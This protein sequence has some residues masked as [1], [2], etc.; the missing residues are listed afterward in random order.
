MKQYILSSLMLIMAPAMMMAQL[1]TPGN[2]TTYSL[3]TLARLEG[4]G[5][6]ANGETGRLSCLVG[7]V[8]VVRLY[9]HH[10]VV[11]PD[12]CCHD[13]NKRHSQKRQ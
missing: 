5:V 6:T 11:T 2:G 7:P 9:G 8:L 3:Q 10:N 13:E 1:T 12:L 4:S